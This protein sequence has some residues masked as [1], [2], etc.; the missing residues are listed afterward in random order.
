MNPLSGRGD[1]GGKAESQVQG[2]WASEGA[3]RPVVL[4]FQFQEAS[5][6]RFWAAERTGPGFTVSAGFAPGP[7]SDITDPQKQCSTGG[8]GTRALVPALRTAF[9]GPL[10]LTLVS[11]SRR[12][13]AGRSASPSVYFWLS[14]PFWCLETQ[15]PRKSEFVKRCKLF[16]RKNPEQFCISRGLTTTKNPPASKQG[17]ERE[18]YLGFLS[19]TDCPRL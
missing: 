14:I 4:G 1:G 9:P 6:P 16:P 2:H 12:R 17:E 7:E 10:P 3:G 11:P 15:V 5:T 13:D 8:L 18:R 19:V